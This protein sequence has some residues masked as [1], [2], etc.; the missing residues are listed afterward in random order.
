MKHSLTFL[1]L[2]SIVFAQSQTTLDLDNWKKMKFR[3]IGPAGMSGRVTAI[4]VDLSN[5]QKILLGSASGG[6]WQSENGGISFK[7]VFDEQSSLAI[8]SIKINQRNPSEIWVGTGEGNPRNSL[9]TGNGIYK[10]IDGGKTWKNMGLEKTKTLHRIVIH[11]ENTDIVFAAALGSPWGPN[12]DRGIFKTS[13]GGKTWKKVLYVNNL[14]G[15]ADLVVDPDNPNKMIAAM[16]EHQRQPWFFNSG[17]EGSGLYITY[18][19]GENWKKITSEDGL[20]GGNIGRCGLAF[21]PSKSKIVYALIEAKENGL[22][23]SEDGGLKW[24]LV[25][26]K[27]IGNRPFYYSEIYVDPKNENR[28]YNVFTYVTRSD[29]GGKSFKNIAD[30]GNA[31]HPDHHALWIHPDKPDFLIDGNDGGAAIS[32]DMGNSWTFISNLPVGQFYHINVDNDF[33]YNVYGG[34]QDNGSWVGPSSVFKPGGI[35]NQDFQELY[36]GDGF[37]VMPYRADSRYGYAMSQGGSLGYYDRKTGNTKFIKPYHPDGLP[38]RFNW[39]AGIAQDPY[40]DCGVYYGSQYLHYSTDCG[41]NWTIISPDL[42]T[43]DTTKLKQKLTGGLTLDAT[44]AENHCT[45]LAIAPSAVDKKV[46]WVSTD[47]GN[48]QITKDGGKNWENVSKGLTGLAK[49]SWIPQIEISKTNAAEAFIVAN[50][51]RRNDYS[52]YAYHT[53]DYGKTWTR[54]ADNTQIKSFVVCILQDTKEPNLL[55]LGADDGLYISFNKGKNWQLWNKGFPQVQVADMKIQDR[56]NDLVIATF[57][58]SLW[59]LDDITPL[60]TLA[61]NNSFLTSDFKL[62]PNNT[63]YNLSYRSYD[64]VRFY[65]QGDFTGDNDNTGGSADFY[66]WSKPKEKKDAKSKD[67]KSKLAN[68][69]KKDEK[70]AK[71][72]DK[73]SDK[74]ED[75]SKDDKVKIIVLNNNGDTIRNKTEK[76][77]GGLDKISWGFETNGFYGVTKKDPEKDDDFK[78][79]GPDALPGKYKIVAIYKGIKDSAN[80]EFKSDPRLDVTQ[81]ELDNKQKALIENAKLR[82]QAGKQYDKIKEARK[83]LKVV[84]ALLAIQDDSVKSKIEKLTK[85]IKTKLDSLDKIFYLPEDTKGITYDDDRFLSILGDA[86]GYLGSSKAGWTST[87]QAAF[88]FAKKKLE[89]VTKGISAFGDDWMKYRAAVEALGV[90]VF[91]DKKE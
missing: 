4:D 12:E 85:P 8:G 1:F 86:G 83:Q 40:N 71:K 24:K 14:T 39:N 77:E 43:N 81:S 73:K 21:A 79:G 64:G 63:A 47:D 61:K 74:K 78:P 10:S 76:I 75:K 65:A 29:D 36:F 37:D 2:F 48:L 46:I 20:P 54:I 70:D 3:N 31:V 72:D 17:G 27:D 51:Y 82:E 66:V 67:D 30:Y 15:A 33:P 11:K 13:D 25:Q 59:V 62:F 22:Y 38:L 45:I 89:E 7:P 87:S 58:R 68:K 23:K 9:N 84:D 5:D 55:F 18:D 80:F 41:D 26:S 69:D 34:M 16:W 53:T 35:K 6:V 50:D 19:A 28:L 90:K 42:T 44:G 49:A 91:K 57:G 56:E 32:R 60:R 52:A 88:S